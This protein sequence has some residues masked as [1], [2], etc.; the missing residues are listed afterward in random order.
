MC[1]LLLRV[2][3]IVE[4]DDRWSTRITAKGRIAFF[5]S[6][7]VLILVSE[8]KFPNCA[9][10]GESVESDEDADV[11]D[12]FVEVRVEGLLPELLHEEVG[13]EEM[14]EVEE[15]EELR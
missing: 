13:A 8:E 5:N 4:G 7:K 2:V 1:Y 9:G 15:R 11:A 10:G 6:S 12:V 14:L 3:E